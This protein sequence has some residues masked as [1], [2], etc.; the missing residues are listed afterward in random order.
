MVAD[1]MGGGCGLWRDSNDYRDASHRAL[2]ALKDYPGAVIAYNANI[3][4]IKFVKPESLERAIRDSGA[5][6]EKIM[7]GIANP[8]GAI[9]SREDFFSGLMLNF[10]RGSAAEWLIADKSVFSW[11]KKEIGYDELR[12]GGQ[13]GIMSNN[14][15]S[16]GIKKVIVH[17]AQM[18]PKQ[19][20]LFLKSE[21][22][23]VP[24]RDG[25]STFSLRRP[26]DAVRE[27]D[28]ELIH[29]ILEFRKDDTINI[30]SKSFKCPRDNR[31]IATYDEKNSGLYIN[32]DFAEGIKSFANDIDC[33][34]L[35]GF[36]LLSP[37]VDYEERI[38]KAMKVLDGIKSSNPALKTHAEMASTQNADVRLA[39]AKRVLS[40]VDSIGV[41]EQE[42][43]DI[44]EVLG[45][46][47]LAKDIRNHSI[48][49]GCKS[50]LIYEGILKIARKLKLKRV[51]FHT[52]GFYV[53]LIDRK[54]WPGSSPE[55]V[56][57]SM[58][59]AASLAAVRLLGGNPKDR[60]SLDGIVNSVPV[61]DNGIKEVDALLSA[62]RDD[63]DFAVIAIPT[64][65][66]EHP[67]STVGLGD[68][69]SSSTFVSELALSKKQESGKKLENYKKRKTRGN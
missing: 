65:V 12:M 7:Y 41:N 4:A 3:D 56:R 40:N 49:A 51:N 62:P 25:D 6:P 35:A 50:I 30:G 46:G 11:M 31:F 59:F 44:L 29:F 52:L 21:S 54:R 2:T 10:S 28:D 33:A 60:D 8:E 53:T 37:A 57:D 55:I 22:I 27:T 69:I 34:I 43:C 63:A 32:P 67:K 66:I 17:S 1:V 15:A 23:M 20:G 13:A 38:E 16:L 5:V 14:L 58:L 39:I 26:S 47:K 48:N 61:N 68:L 45:E 19:A 18:S 64:L 36:H 9:R 24:Y 42:L